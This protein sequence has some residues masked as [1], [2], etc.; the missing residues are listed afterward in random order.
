MPERFCPACGGALS[1]FDDHGRERLRCARCGR[2]A[3]RNPKPAVTAI[4]RR[5]DAVLLS[6]RAHEPHRGAWDLPGGFLESGEHPEEG[7]R[8]ELREETGLDARV[9]RLVH[10]GLGRYWEDDTLNLVYEVAAQG[11]PVASDDSS[12]LRWFPLGSLPAMAF[13]HERE[14]LRV[15]SGR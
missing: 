1:P 3:Y 2:V 5:G 15:Y 4:L 13:P 14:A 6:R 7:V 9:L 8:R 10:I 12:E 11:D